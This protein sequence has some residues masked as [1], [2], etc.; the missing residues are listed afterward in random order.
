M[1]GG[2]GVLFYLCSTLLLTLILQA[3]MD[4]SIS[5]IFFMFALG[6]LV[7]FSYGVISG[8]SAE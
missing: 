3:V 2:A 6:V 8:S 4:V 7:A 1:G 5:S